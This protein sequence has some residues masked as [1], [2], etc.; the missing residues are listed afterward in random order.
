MRFNGI[1]TRSRFLSTTSLPVI[2]E[3]KFKQTIIDEK[4]TIDDDGIFLVKMIFKFKNLEILR[5]LITNFRYIYQTKTLCLV[6]V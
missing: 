5:F 1:K 3:P 2:I 6:L 4:F